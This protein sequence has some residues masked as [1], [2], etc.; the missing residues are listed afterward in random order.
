MGRAGNHTAA[1]ASQMLEDILFP[2]VCIHTEL[3]SFYHSFCCRGFKGIFECG[4]V[5]L[6][7][8]EEALAGL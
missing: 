4:S 2:S 1:V 5:S 3:C 6:L 8:S 7:V